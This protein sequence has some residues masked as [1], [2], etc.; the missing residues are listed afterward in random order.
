MRGQT[1]AFDELP[2]T[3]SCKGEINRMFSHSKDTDRLR[4]LKL[5]Y[6]VVLEMEFR[7]KRTDYPMSKSI[8][9]E[10]CSGELNN[11]TLTWLS[12]DKRPAPR[13]EE[14]NSLVRGPAVCVEHLGSDPT[15]SLDSSNDLQ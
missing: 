10:P 5:V 12:V 1:L 9:N 7:C 15:T 8:E 6:K 4:I 2:A 14:A 13:V 3:H 11:L